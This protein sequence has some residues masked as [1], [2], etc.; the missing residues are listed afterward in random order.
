MRGFVAPAVGL[1]LAA[2]A[3][4]PERTPA[5]EALAPGALASSQTFTAP[6][7][8]WP[9]NEWWRAYGDPQL[10]TLI[11]EALQN[12]PTLAQAQARL[13]IANAARAAARAAGGPSLTLNASASEEKQSYNV[14][15]PA[16]FVPQDYNDYGRAT[17]DF[18]YSF[19]FWG[20]NR[21][22]IAA[23]TSDARAAEAEAAETRITLSTAVA[24]AYADLSRLYA[25][26]DISARALDVRTQTVDLVGRRVQS[27]IDT[28]G[29]LRQAEA[30][31]PTARAEVAALDEQIAQTRNRLAA[32]L[33]AGPDRGLT[34]ERPHAA[35]LASFGLPNN[36]A[37]DLIGRRPDVVAARWRAEA[38][39]E[40]IGQARASFYPN[41]NLV[42]F[43]GLQSLG[44]DNLARTGSDIGSIGPAL[45]LPIFDSGR[46]QAN[47]RRADAERDAAVA[48][49]NATLTEALRE[50]ADVV[51]SSRSL[52]TQISETSAALAA[53]EDAYRIARLRY[54]GGLSNYQS[55]L[56][57]ED[58]LLDQRRAL[59]A[60][61]SHRL[62]LDIA[63]VR[64]LGGGFSTNEANL[65]PPAREEQSNG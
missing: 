27:G 29:E 59:A 36:I 41:V 5:A 10:D 32:L 51:A 62:T 61:E 3:T 58:R 50:I 38:A 19:D 40:R 35:T 8:A 26:R 16:D 15:I 1:L 34:I 63:L 28:Q 33:G 53:N 47:L 9:S 20:R 4:M 52:A 13:R 42:A 22:A 24:E 17:L 57:S 11:S 21:A 49:Y 7:A 25:E 46:L 48:S 55:V 37:A 45:S 23:A 14:G 12:S 43:V 54:D 2:C 56:I 31:P 60:L 6:G 65:T 64:A 39:S 44:L 30:G 18:D